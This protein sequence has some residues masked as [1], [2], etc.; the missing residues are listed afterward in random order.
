VSR[1]LESASAV[2]AA[3]GHGPAVM[4]AVDRIAVAD[5]IAA[6]ARMVAAVAVAALV[7]AAAA[8]AGPAARTAAVAAGATVGAVPGNPAGA[9]G[10]FAHGWYRVTSLTAAAMSASAL[11]VGVQQPA[12]RLEQVQVQAGPVRAR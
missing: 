3:V 5:R 12:R 1:V 8:V 2:G 6:V 10:M 11:A 4:R 9:A 7:V